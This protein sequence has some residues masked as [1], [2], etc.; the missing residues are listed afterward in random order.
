MPMNVN[1]L[2]E[3]KNYIKDYFPLVDMPQI[4][5]LHDTATIKVTT[6]LA[7]DILHRTYIYQFVVKKPKKVVIDNQ[8]ANKNDQMVYEFYR[9]KLLTI[10]Y[11]I[12]KEISENEVKE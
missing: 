8:Q 10:V 4:F 2:E 12:P 5:G 3:M 11:E 9:Q 7:A 1:T 6:D